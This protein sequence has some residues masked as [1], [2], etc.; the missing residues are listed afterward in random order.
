MF[1]LLLLIVGL[2]FPLQILAQE[3][4]YDITWYLDKLVIEND[5][6]YSPTWEDLTFE[7]TM[8]LNSDDD[9][10]EFDGCSGWSWLADIDMA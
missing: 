1:A 3:E 10:I 9:W 2:F 4:I 7:S 5:T 8:F 6:L